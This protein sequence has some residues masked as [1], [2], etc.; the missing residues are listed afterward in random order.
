MPSIIYIRPYVII[1]G[2]RANEAMSKTTNK[3]YQTNSEKQTRALSQTKTHPQRATSNEQ[4]ATL[5]LWLRLKP[6]M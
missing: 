5:T 1:K 3:Y 2:Q 4:R 6:S